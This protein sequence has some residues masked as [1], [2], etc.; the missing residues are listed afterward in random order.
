MPA[1]PPITWEL[2][3]DQLTPELS[4]RMV[5]LPGGTFIMGDNQGEYDDEKPEHE[6]EVSS[7]Y[8]GQYLVSQA[9]WAEIMEGDPSHFKGANKAS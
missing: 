9:L 5:H 8:L 1:S 7:F 4:I 3:I 2:Q 6:V